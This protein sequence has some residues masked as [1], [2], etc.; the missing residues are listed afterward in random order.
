MLIL[1]I[2]L[3]ESSVLMATATTSLNGK[4]IGVNID[5]GMSLLLT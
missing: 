5:D 2:G 1:S 3:W 4:C